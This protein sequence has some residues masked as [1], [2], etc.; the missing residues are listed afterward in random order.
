M[1]P[2]I[3]A[4]SL[5][6]P[7][8]LP[9]VEQPLAPTTD[10][11]PLGQVSLKEQFPMVDD[12]R[13]GGLLRA[14]YDYADSDLSADG[15]N[16]A[17]FRLYDAQ[18]WFQAE[19]YGYELFIRTDA[20]EA[21]AFPPIESG[22]GV[23]DFGIR[24]AYIRKG[25]AED[26]HFYFGQFK[27]P[28]VASGNIGD[29]NLAMIERTRIG[30]LFSAPGAYQPGAAVTYDHGPF[31]AKVVVQNG[32]DGATDGNGVVVRG[33]YKL[34]DGQGIQEGALDK[35][36][37]WSA[38]FGAGYFSDDSDIGGDDFGSAWAL[39]AYATCNALSLHAE[40]LGADDNLAGRALGNA[41]SSATPYSATVGYLFMPDWEGFLR[42]QDLDNDASATIIGAG[43]NYY[44]A[45]H[46]AKWQLN[47][48]QY[49]DDDIDGTIVQFGFSVGLSQPTV[50]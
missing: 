14:Y 13:V 1:I 42:Y 45:E 38:T 37:G 27:C 19:L 6:A 26:F 31:H 18:V 15:D 21:S 7:F 4:L 17:G 43:V 48:S 46:S 47:L 39:D 2:W 25:F 41:D 35:P 9:E 50:N 40:V 44:V 30:Q 10:K 28:L 20:A 5:L 3:P 33:E 32:A 29:G 11:Q 16:I 8:A 34:G 36:E 22:S 49:D 24:D 23:G 12:M